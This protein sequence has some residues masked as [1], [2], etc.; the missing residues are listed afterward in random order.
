MLLLFSVFFCFYLIQVTVFMWESRE[1][2]GGPRAIQSALMYYLERWNT[3]CKRIV[4]WADNTGK[5]TKNWTWNHFLDY[6]VK[7]GWF[8]SVCLK[9][10]VKGHTFMGGNGPDALHSQLK[11][12]TPRD[13]VISTIK[14]WI[15]IA[16]EVGK[17]RWTV[18]HLKEKLHRNWTV[19]LT[20]SFWSRPM[21]KLPFRIDEW[22]WYNC[23]T[24]PDQS[25][26]DTKH[27][28]VVWM[29]HA[30]D[31]SRRV[32]PVTIRKRKH[33]SFDPETF[34]IKDIDDPAFD[35]GPNP[36]KKS[37]C[38]GIIKCLPLM[39]LAQQTEWKGILVNRLGKKEYK[40]Q[41]AQTF[42]KNNDNDDVC[43]TDSGDD[44]DTRNQKWKAK[45]K[46]D[47]TWRLKNGIRLRGY[48]ADYT[49]VKR[50]APVDGLSKERRERQKRNKDERKEY[51]LNEQRRR[52]RDA[53]SRRAAAK[54]KQTHD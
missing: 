44:T 31:P 46:R 45:Q 30:H 54:A 38:A 48:R 36:L 23:G 16:K 18:V 15:E 9:F 32:Q 24:G 14:D 25:G 2:E 1:G 21:K 26:V 35:M 22:V 13:G 42:E 52:R 39:N 37:V 41:R 34:R 51:L 6:L 50:L 47:D 12:G 49:G 17:D 43:D 19:Y 5:G 10:Y 33:G 28:G 20:T 53:E 11:K 29:R 40:K 8:E 3:G 27:P 4:I 7:E